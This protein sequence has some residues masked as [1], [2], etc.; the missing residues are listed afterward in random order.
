MAIDALR[1][2]QPKKFG[3]GLGGKN[4][5]IGDTSISP[6]SSGG[7][8]TATSKKAIDE[9]VL[10]YQADLHRWRKLRW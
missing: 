6:A 9:I 8:V 1:I 4:I 10:N 5:K 2:D 7:N 3:K